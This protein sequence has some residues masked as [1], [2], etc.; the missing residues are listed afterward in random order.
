MTD[1][2]KPP[3]ALTA[4]H[5]T[6]S[7][8]CGAE[9]FDGWLQEHALANH[10]SGNARVF[11]TTR[12][13]RVLGY[14]A[15]AAASGDR[16]EAPAHLADGRVPAHIPCLLLSHLAVDRSEQHKGLGRG[17]LIDAI[18]RTVAVSEEIGVRALLVQAQDDSVRAYC[19]HLSEFVVSSTDPRQLFLP[20]SHARH[21]LAK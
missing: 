3:V 7:F 16:G 8:R 14:Y 1:P 12:D 15:L 20:I 9:E 4:Q 21:L 6:G 2:L 10:V 5:G 19:L 13:E 11:V 18:R 17:L